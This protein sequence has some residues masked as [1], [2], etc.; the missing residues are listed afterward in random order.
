M[1]EAGQILGGKYEIISVIGRGGTSVVYLALHIRLKQKW[2]IKEIDRESCE[3]YGIICRQLLTEADILKKLKHLSLPQIIDII[4]EKDTIWLV[5]EYVEGECLKEILRREGRI[6]EEKVLEWGRQLCQVL[7]YLHTRKPPIIYRDLKPSNL[8]I[9]KDGRLVLIDF[10]TAREYC[11][12][13]KWEDTTYLGTR[14]YAAPEQYGGLGQTDA[15]TDIYCLGFTFYHLL[16][17]FNPEKPPYKMHPPD[18]WEDMVSE[19]MKEIIVKCTRLDPK[20]RYQDCEELY[21]VL[22]GADKENR[23]HIQKER[24]N[25]RNFLGILLM[26]F[27][28]GMLCL[29]SRVLLVQYREKAVDTYLAIAE[30]SQNPEITKKNY[31]KALELHPSNT[32]IYQSLAAHY[33]R[34]NDFTTERASA[35]MNL[36]L[37]ESEGYLILERFQKQNPGKYLDF[38]YLV[39]IG[40]FYDMGGMTGK[41]SAESW[42]R[43]VGKNH[44]VMWDQE[45]RKRADSYRKICHYYNTFLENGA[46]K[47]GEKGTEDYYSFYQVLKELNQIKIS[48]ESSKSDISAAYLISKEVAIEI[49]DYGDAFLQHEKISKKMMERELT[50]IEERIKIL[51]GEKSKAEMTELKKVTEDAIKKIGLLSEKNMCFQNLFEGIS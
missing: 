41:Q 35:L 6:E 25:I 31:R 40:Y 38:C 42:F 10:G 29:G 24:K 33:I 37:S 8:M 46:D 44:P 5:M 47:S 18:V 2:A 28:S 19:H 15:R 16:T 32:K 50:V 49:A 12:K 43:E 14:G 39:G 26:M 17:G 20:D 34:T 9:K 4:E 21:D 22:L 45:K 7:F 30:K 3:N 48:R 13:E 36:I 51:E 23:I 27:F 1:L 11:Y